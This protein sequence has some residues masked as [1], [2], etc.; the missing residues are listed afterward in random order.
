[1]QNVR[2]HARLG[3]RQTYAPMIVFLFSYMLLRNIRSNLGL[4]V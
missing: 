1:M 2:D 4:H 3:R